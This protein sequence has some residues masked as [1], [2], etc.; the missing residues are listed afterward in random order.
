MTKGATTCSRNLGWPLKDEE[1]AHERVEGKEHPLLREEQVQ[2]L[3]KPGAG[4]YWGGGGGC[5][6]G[7]RAR[8]GAFSLRHCPPHIQDFTAL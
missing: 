7:G 3:G 5:V 8:R 6:S 2:R 4:A 1:G